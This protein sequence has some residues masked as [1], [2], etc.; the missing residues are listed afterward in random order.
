MSEKTI[1]VITCDGPQCPVECR[2]VIPVGWITFIGTPSRHLCTGC[3]TEENVRQ[4]M[5]HQVMEGID[6]R[7]GD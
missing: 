5:H 3:A 6:K 2:D 4:Q 7:R 1:T